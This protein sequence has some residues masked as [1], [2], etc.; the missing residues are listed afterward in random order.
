MYWI[1]CTWGGSNSVYHHQHEFKFKS[2][3]PDQVNFLIAGSCYRHRAFFLTM[4]AQGL[5]QKKNGRASRTKY[6]YEY[7]TRI[8]FFFTLKGCFGVIFFFS[9]IFIYIKKF[10]ARWNT[11]PFFYDTFIYIFRKTLVHFFNQ[12]YCISILWTHRNVIHVRAHI[13]MSHACIDKLWKMNIWTA[14]VQ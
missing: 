14:Y 4:C 7:I 11:H 5:T 12:K 1:L 10:G 6:I 9:I 8:S 3:W 13:Q 2:R